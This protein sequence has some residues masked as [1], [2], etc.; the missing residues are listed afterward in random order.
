MGQERRIQ[1]AFRVSVLCYLMQMKQGLQPS[2]SEGHGLCSQVSW[3]WSP[4]RHSSLP[5]LE[6]P[7]QCGF[8]S[9]IWADLPTNASPSVRPFMNILCLPMPSR[10]CSAGLPTQRCLQFCSHPWGS[11]PAGV[12]SG[13]LCS[14]RLLLMPAVNIHHSL[15]SETYT[16]TISYV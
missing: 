10:L 6:G 2:S 5:T 8:P 14:I 11:R 12:C 3:D 4:R 7:L 15:S 16:C 13:L 9:L 1:P